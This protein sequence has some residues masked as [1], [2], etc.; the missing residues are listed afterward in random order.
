MIVVNIH[1]K[2]RRVFLARSVMVFS[3]VR[4]YSTP[5]LNL[6]LA[7]SWAMRLSSIYSTLNPG[8]RPR[9]SIIW[10]LT[11]SMEVGFIDSLK[12]TLTSTFSGILSPRW[13]GKIPVISGRILSIIPTE[14]IGTLSESESELQPLTAIRAMSIDQHKRW[15]VLK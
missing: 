11:V 15:Y 4:V 6:V 5:G 14:S 3:K 8:T 9:S 13:G 1:L 12:Y 2:G 10:K 7:T